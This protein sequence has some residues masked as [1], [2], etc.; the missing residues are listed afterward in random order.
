MEYWF[1]FF[2]VLIILYLYFI[3]INSNLCRIH[4][5]IDYVALE[6][7]GKEYSEPASF[8]N[9][10]LMRLYSPRTGISITKKDNDY[11]YYVYISDNIH[12]KS[13]TDFKILYKNKEIKISDKGIFPRYL[14][15]SL[16]EGLLSFCV[17]IN[18]IKKINKIKSQKIYD[19]I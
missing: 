16:K 2:S 8:D 17:N 3:V 5:R 1:G 13:V 14:I 11:E 9:L 15:K 6:S 12:N 4:T 7:L 18:G 10:E 19:P